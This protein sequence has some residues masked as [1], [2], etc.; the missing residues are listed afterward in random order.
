[1]IAKIRQFCN[2][3]V[4]LTSAQ[5]IL[6]MRHTLLGRIYGEGLGV[7]HPPPPKVTCGFPIQ[8]VF[9]KKKTMWF[10]GVEVEQETSAP[11]LVPRPVR[12][13]R[14]TRGGLEPSAIGEFSRQALQVTSH[15]KSPRTTGNEAGVHP[16]L[17]KNPGSAPGLR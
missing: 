3:F 6:K 13:I 11:S 17:K 2:R 15:P 16:L 4:I 1:M 10:V 5:L 12:A 14:V 9:C 8:L 7:A